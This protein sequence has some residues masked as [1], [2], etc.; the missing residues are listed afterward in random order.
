MF[1][2]TRRRFLAGLPALALA[3]CEAE[4]NVKPEL[5]RV[6][7]REPNITGTLFLPASDQGKP[8]VLCLTG[9][10]GG[11]WEDP[12]RALAAEG[13]PALALATHNFVGLP[14]RLREIPVD[15]VERAANWL[16][17]RA[18]PQKGFVAVRGWSRG[19]ELALILASLSRSVN[20]VVAYAPRCYVALEHQKPNNFGDPTAAPAWTFAGRPVAGVPLPEEQRRDR[21]HPTLEDLHGIAV[22]NIPGPVLFISGDSDQ[23]V[24]GTTPNFSCESAMRRLDL[25]GFRHRHEHLNYP[26]AGHNIAGPPP[27]TG[28]P[29]AGGTVD[30]I[31]AAV[32]DSWKRSLAFLTEAAK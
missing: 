18:Q 13:F 3:G 7:V 30:G 1:D 15:D 11:L 19:G 25:A 28:E 6:P 5:Q 22:E 26:N 10:E 12:A 2:L 16:R 32:A 29:L 20:A 14:P 24:A 21:E 9:A 23:G 31:A 17:R 27:F 8:A 4:A